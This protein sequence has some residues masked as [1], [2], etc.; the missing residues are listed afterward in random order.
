MDRGQNGVGDGRVQGLCLTGKRLRSESWQTRR[1]AHRTAGRRFEAGLKDTL[2]ANRLTETG[3]TTEQVGLTLKEEAKPWIPGE[4]E[5]AL[6]I[7]AK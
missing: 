6:E 7:K 5:E 3:P 1:N 4:Y 2:T